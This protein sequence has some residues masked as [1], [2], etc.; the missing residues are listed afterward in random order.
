LKHAFTPA[1]AYRLIK[2]AKTNFNRHPYAPQAWKDV[3]NKLHLFVAINEKSPGF[4]TAWAASWMLNDYHGK[5]YGID[6]LAPKT[7]IGKKEWWLC[8]EFKAWAVCTADGPSLFNLVA[9]EASHS[10]DYVIRGKMQEPDESH[11][12]F[13]RVL[14]DM[15]GGTEDYRFPH[16]SYVTKRIEQSID[17]FYGCSIVAE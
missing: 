9:H 2:K 13:F 17:S 10:L 7:K 3:F 14:V 11:D 15:M 1:V 4:P 8:L 16:Q 6:P 12:A 5:T